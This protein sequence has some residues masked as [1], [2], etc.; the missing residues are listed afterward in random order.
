MNHDPN[1]DL[2]GKLSNRYKDYTKS[3]FGISSISRDINNV[4]LNKAQGERS[5]NESD[6]KLCQLCFDNPRNICFMPCRHLICC[7]FCAVH[8]KVC[9]ICKQEPVMQIKTFLS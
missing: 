3:T 9:P 7:G 4:I 8:L 1:E 6:F 2:N 5:T